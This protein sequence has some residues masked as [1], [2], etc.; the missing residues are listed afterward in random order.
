METE[1]LDDQLPDQPAEPEFQTRRGLP[2]GGW[3]QLRHPDML[4]K[5]DRDEILKA[6]K[7]QSFGAAGVELT[8]ST[9]IVIVENWHLPYLPDAVAPHRNPRLLGELTIKDG[10][11]LEKI[12]EEYKLI[13]FPDAPSID[14]AGIPGSPTPPASD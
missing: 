8:N 1:P 2:S 6:V 3:V 12:T 7:A 9:I 14:Q 11:A 5:K 13:L 10:N 4:R